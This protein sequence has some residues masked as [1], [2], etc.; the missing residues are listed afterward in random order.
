MVGPLLKRSWRIPIRYFHVRLGFFV[1]APFNWGGIK[2]RRTPDKEI[3]PNPLVLAWVTNGSTNPKLHIEFSTITST[4]HLAS[5]KFSIQSY[6]FW[7]IGLV[8]EWPQRPM[9]QIQAIPRQTSKEKGTQICHRF[10]QTIGLTVTR[11]FSS[12]FDWPPIMALRN[13]WQTNEFLV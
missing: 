3:R 11:N 7:T 12:H 13:S 8:M 5:R 4:D 10:V 2:T 6:K 9:W 1:I